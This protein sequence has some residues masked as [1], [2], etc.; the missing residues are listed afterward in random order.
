MIESFLP[1]VPLPQQKKT[2]ITKK[3]PGPWVDCILLENK[4]V[5][6]HRVRRAGTPGEA[7]WGGS[8]PQGT[9][10]C[11]GEACWTG[12]QRREASLG[13]ATP[14]E[15]LLGSAPGRRAKK[16]KE[17]KKK[18]KEKKKRK[19]KKEKKNDPPNVETLKTFKDIERLELSFVVSLWLFL[20]HV[21]SA[22]GCCSSLG[23]H[24]CR[25]W[26]LGF[27]LRYRMQPFLSL[28]WCLRLIMFAL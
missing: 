20:L 13:G 1:S 17:T 14:G 4:L 26:G 5:S 9:L 21:L 11:R 8:A 22:C 7:C 6:Y 24:F 16:K 28:C 19:G 23:C 3:S 2:K 15:A 27:Q 12:E 25:G 18:R 10:A